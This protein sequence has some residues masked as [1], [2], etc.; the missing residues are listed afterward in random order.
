VTVLVAIADGERVTLAADSWAV[1]GADVV[2][3]G[4]QK[5]R[6]IDVAGER[7]LMSTAGPIQ[8]GSLMR[9]RLVIGELPADTVDESDAWAHVV[10]ETLTDVARER[11]VVDSDGDVSG[12][13][14][15]A[16]R[17]HLWE[18]TE[19]VAIRVSTFASLGSGAQVAR[20][21]LDVVLGNGIAA[22]EAARLA[23]EVACRHVTSCGGE[24][25]VAI[26]GPAEGPSAVQ[27][28]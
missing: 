28:S 7:V 13:A 10:A 12:V 25:T 23:C 26:T 17:T 1:D 16:W 14:F 19:N 20:G 6:A 5:I 11:N 22:T 21:A 18:I 24:I 4:R 15:L 2:W 3:P 9:H 27:G 8:M